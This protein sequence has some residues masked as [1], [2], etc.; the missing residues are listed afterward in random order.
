MILDQ[1]GMQPLLKGFA[2]R[3][4]ST[5]ISQYFWHRGTKKYQGTHNTSNVNF[6]YHDTSWYR[7]YRP[8]LLFT[9]RASKPLKT[10]W[11]NLHNATPTVKF[12]KYSLHTITNMSNAAGQVYVAELWSETERDKPPV[13][14]RW[15]SGPGQF[16]S[17][18]SMLIP[19]DLYDDMAKIANNTLLSTS[20]PLY[21]LIP[22][23]FQN[24][25]TVNLQ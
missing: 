10:V 20:L 8:A 11:F 1:P 17:R 12:I 25:F 19:M 24:S 3:V 15:R 5:K 7:Q 22:I 16:A 21:W 9:E 23:N 14:R 18:F 4:V 2:T 6:W 13:S